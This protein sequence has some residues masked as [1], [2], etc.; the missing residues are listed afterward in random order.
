MDNEKHNND[1]EDFEMPK[2]DIRQE[3]EFKKMK[4]NLESGA[5]FPADMS[6]NL[7]PEIESRFLDTIMNFEKAFKNSKNISIFD[8]IGCPDF[9]PENVLN[10]TEIIEE[11]NKI[12]QLLF[13]KGIT[14]EATAEYDDEDRMIY[15]F[16]TEEF[17]L[18]EVNDVHI[19]GVISCFTYEKFHQNHKYD[20]QQETYDILRLI[21]NKKSNFYDEFHVHDLKNHVA[22]NNFTS[23][24]KK[25]KIKM[26]RNVKVIH[27]DVKAISNFNIVFWGKIAGTGEKMH[28]SGE[29]SLD[30]EYKSGI[31]TAV[32]VNLPVNH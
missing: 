11:L 8:K 14:L 29:G 7:P 2:L 3:N 26:I 10:D 1:D 13:E 25:F 21:L 31:W 18:I 4:L 22:F 9:I 20:I 6:K 32:A 5:V 30:F 24:F 17:F 12:R 27:D 28:F 23:L 15:K 19:P 16:I